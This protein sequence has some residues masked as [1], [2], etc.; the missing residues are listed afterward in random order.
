MDAATWIAENWAAAGRQCHIDAVMQQV[1]EHKGCGTMGGS[2]KASCGSGAGQDDLPHRN[3]GEGQEPSLLQR[4]GAS[5]LC[6]HACRRR[7]GLQHPMQLLQ[8]QI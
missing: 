5:S 6:A 2:G 1:A 7:A 4:R 8:S 3:L